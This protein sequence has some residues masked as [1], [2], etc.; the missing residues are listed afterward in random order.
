[1]DAEQ[2]V[3]ELVQVGKPGQPDERFYFGLLNQQLKTH[4][5][6]VQARDTFRAL[7]QSPDINREQ[8][9]L[10]TIL[11]RYN[12][13]RINWYAEYRDVQAEHASLQEELEA[14]RKE[15]EALELKIQAITDLETS[16][17]TRKEEGQVQAQE[18]ESG[19]AQEPGQAQEQR[20]IQEQGP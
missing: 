3:A 4:A 1:M 6:W 7:S 18:Q 17:S 13:S 9:Q 8:R 5:S 10:A 12:Q 20:Q 2:V 15:N 14:T 19:Q 16:I 11:M